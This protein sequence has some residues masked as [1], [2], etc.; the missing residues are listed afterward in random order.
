MNINLTNI[1]HLFLFCICISYI[2]GIGHYLNGRFLQGDGWKTLNEWLKTAKESEN[3]DFVK[4]LLILL[5]KC[6][7]NL[8][9]LKENDTPKVIKN[10]SRSSQDEG[11]VEIASVVVKSWTEV[12][13]VSTAQSQK[14]SGSTKKV[15]KRTKHDSGEGKEENKKSKR[16]SVSG[17]DETSNGSPPPTSVDGK[18]GGSVD[19]GSN[20]SSSQ[21]SVVDNLRP[22]PSTVVM[23]P[24]KSNMDGLIN[25]ATTQ[26]QKSSGITKSVSSI[27]L[28]D[29]DLSSKINKVGSD[30]GVIND[31]NAAAVNG[32][33]SKKSVTATAPATTSKTPDKPASPPQSI[34]TGTVTNSAVVS[35]PPIAIPKESDLFANVLGSSA[36][37]KIT[38]KRKIVRQNKIDGGDEDTAT[39]NVKRTNSVTDDSTSSRTPADTN[40]TMST[41]PPN[42]MMRSNSMSN[43]PQSCPTPQGPAKSFPRGCLSVRSAME[44]KKVRFLP[45]PWIKAVKLFEIEAEERVNMYRIN[46]LNAIAERKGEANALKKNYSIGKDDNENNSLNLAP[47]VLIAVDVPETSTVRGSRSCERDIQEQRHRTVL[48]SIFMNKNQ[49]PDTPSEPDKCE[50]IA[51]SAPTEPV[52]DIPTMDLTGTVSDYS[53]YIQPEPKINAMYGQPGFQAT[54]SNYQLDPLIASQTQ[55]PSLVSSSYL[56]PSFSSTYNSNVQPQPS[57]SYNPRIV[58]YGNNNQGINPNNFNNTN[59]P[60]MFNRNNNGRG[61]GN[62]RQSIICKDFINGRCKYPNCRYSHDVP[63]STQRSRSTNMIHNQ[64]VNDDG[65]EWS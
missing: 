48:A 12:I 36:T 65:M 55:S 17:V 58:D 41:P 6:P 16:G 53:G 62:G 15:K 57:G 37:N 35:K 7:V 21:S 30:S 52:K 50:I 14:S 54:S 33:V 51:M 40:D 60:N 32:S 39:S 42:K 61:R 49:A 28:K 1:I 59:G 24:G 43:P 47:W 27:S 29:G 8:D 56:Q 22:A 9:R 20:D 44:K 23:K 19:E 18:D 10:L 31:T 25:T 45:D 3:H 63:P 13:G 38:I 26:S 4:E 46:S 11:V 34:N 64:R 5:Q 2:N